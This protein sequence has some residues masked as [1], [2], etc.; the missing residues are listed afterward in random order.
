MT[1]YKFEKCRVR[2]H[3]EAEQDKI[4]TATEKF[5]KGVTKCR[6]IKSKTQS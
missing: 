5:V 1:E 4:R 2:I 3:G 6:K